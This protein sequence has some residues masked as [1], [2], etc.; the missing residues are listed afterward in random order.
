MKKILSFITT[1]T[2]LI[3][4]VGCT[5]STE[6]KT[7][8]KNKTAAS[9]N[10]TSQV[11][12][13]TKKR[14]DLKDK[15]QGTKIVI[16]C[17]GSSEYSIVEGTKEEEAINAI[18]DE[19]YMQTGIS[20]DFEVYYLGSNM[21]T[22]LST[23]LSSGDQVD[24]AISHARYD[25]G[26][27]DTAMS[28]DIY[29]DLKDLIDK[30]GSNIYKATDMDTMTTIDDQIIGIPSYVDYKKFGILV[31]KDYMKACGYTDNEEEANTLG[32]TLLTTIEQF[33]DMCQKMKSKNVTGLSK[34]SA[35]SVTGAIWD[36][37]KVFTGAFGEAGYF[38][39]VAEKDKDGNITKVLPGFG[40]S[41]YKD[42]LQMEYD[43]VTKYQILDAN[44]NSTSLEA[45]EGEFV[46]GK[47]G[48]FLTD[49]SVT[50]LIK[51]ARRCKA[52][53][54]NAEFTIL[55]PLATEA[56]PDK[57][58]FIPQTT[59]YMAAVV[60]K[61]TKVAQEIVKFVN[62]MYSD[63]DNYNLCKYGVD[64]VHWINNNDG[65]YSYPI[66]SS[67]SA[68]PYSGILS[69]VENQ[70]MSNLIYSEYTEQEKAWLEAAKT[71]EYVDNHVIDS[72]LPR[73]KAM[74]QAHALA[75]NTYY[76]TT[77]VPVWYGTKNP[78][79]EYEGTTIAS[80]G[81]DVYLEDDSSYITWL[82]SQY[83]MLLMLRG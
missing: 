47:T 22:K 56:N 27:D 2:L 59:A 6:L 39:Y 67:L 70:N 60:M 25:S 26:I 14:Y 82:T 24:I 23:S 35:Y 62:W 74:S 51:V 9:S 8:S 42:L 77:A 3:V 41:E 63:T 50:H 32:L 75:L 34:D 13:K 52:K 7:R 5:K 46:S 48:V 83:K 16:Y 71:F 68:L 58:G 4:L 64:G 36:V 55:G 73:N 30:Y 38:G 18:E 80:Y 28:S 15:P 79:S 54:A 29:Y 31:R 1:F 49:P 44:T 57:K 72:I 53:N 10:Q 45:A 40:T 19:Y 66:G 76:N 12:E 65:T 61:Q 43:W 33:E 20:L 81:L 11:G 21:G 37:E 78:S 17:G 69:L